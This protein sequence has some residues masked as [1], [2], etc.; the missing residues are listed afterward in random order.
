MTRIRASLLVLVLALVSAAC[1]GSITEPENT[2]VAGSGSQTVGAPS[3]NTG[4]AGSGS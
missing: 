4:V 2:G 1:Q 3:Y